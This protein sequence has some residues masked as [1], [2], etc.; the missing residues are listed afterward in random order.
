M[1]LVFL[2]SSLFFFLLGP[3]NLNSA[4]LE[5]KG[6]GTFDGKLCNKLKDKERKPTIEKAKK[7]AW[8]SFTAT[9]N[10]ARMNQYKKIENEFTDKLDNFITEVSVL[11]SSSNTDLNTC[12]I[13]VRIKINEVAVNSKLSEKS[14]IG[15]VES[16]EG[17][18]I[19]F[20]F[21]GRQITSSK[22]FDE[23]R[24]NIKSVEETKTTYK[25]TTGGSTERKSAIE[26][27]DVIATTDFD[28]A[29]NTVL[30][31][32]GFEV[33]EY[34]D[35][36]SNCG[37]E[38]LANIKSEF[39]KSDEISPASR[40]KAIDA[41]KKCDVRY[42]SIGFMNVSVPDKDPVSGNERVFVSVNGRVDDI[43]KKL[44]KRVASVG[45]IQYSGLGPDQNTARRNALQKAATEAGK[46][47]VDQ[48]NAKGL[49]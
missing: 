11:D 16:G 9:F 38:S 43:A 37:G 40:K 47:I 49:K 19:S 22:S 36:F 20:I 39:S 27:Y 23:K 30:T 44:P 25:A 13:L 1:K 14:A 6:K 8:N 24:V 42:F 17:S 18:T 4:E 32:G 3:V 46:I 2:F 41:A 29:L 34:A 10:Q 21:V 28:S 33:S 5:F 45:P 31:D 12:D 15:S 26:K 48:L 7:N 35:V